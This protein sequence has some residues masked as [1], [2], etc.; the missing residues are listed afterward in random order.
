[1]AK[2]KLK[3]ENKVVEKKTKTKEKQAFWFFFSVILIL[4][5]IILTPYLYSE[6]FNK[7]EYGGVQFDKVKYGELNFYHGVFPVIYK[8]ELKYRYNVYFRTDPRKNEI[9]V[10][11]NFTLSKNVSIGLSK[12]VERCSDFI[13]SQSEIGKFI[14]V[15]P[16]IQNLDSGIIE[17]EKAQELGLEQINCSKANKDNTVFLYKLSDTPSVDLESENCFVLN[18]GDCKSLETTERFIIATMAQINGKELK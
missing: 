4:S 10:N 18:I 7:F 9:P 2:K 15:F 12:D 8:G 5:L 13:L 3:K 17:K 14:G 1:M 11:T 16:W 6:T